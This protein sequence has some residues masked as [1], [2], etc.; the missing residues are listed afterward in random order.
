MTDT[1]EAFQQIRVLLET[2]N[3]PIAWNLFTRVLREA[4]EAGYD[5]G[6]TDAYNTED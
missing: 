3:Q 5:N 4:Y 6:Y 1:H 2:D